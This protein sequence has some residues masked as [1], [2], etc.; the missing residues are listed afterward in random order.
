M[1]THAPTLLAMDTYKPPA[2]DDEYVPA[3]EV[4]DPDAVYAVYSDDCDQNVNQDCDPDSTD[5]GQTEVAL[6]DQDCRQNS[7][8]TQMMT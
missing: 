8:T 5:V 3:E 7:P 4:Y 2:E 6:A 1:T